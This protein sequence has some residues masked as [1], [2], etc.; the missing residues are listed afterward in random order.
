VEVVRVSYSKR[1][2]VGLCVLVLAAGPLLVACDALLGNLKDGPADAGSP[3]GPKDA[4]TPDGP[5]D[6]GTPDGRKDAR[7]PDATAANLDWTGEDAAIPGFTVDAYSFAGVVGS[8]P[9]YVATTGGTFVGIY[10][11]REAGV[12][13][14]GVPLSNGLA[15]AGSAPSAVT[16]SGTFIIGSPSCASIPL[17]DYVGPWTL[18]KDD[19]FWADG[20]G[21]VFSKSFIADAGVA[22]FAMVEGIGALAFD[23][24]E[25][26]TGL[27]IVTKGVTVLNW[28]S[29]MNLGRTFAI[30]SDVQATATSLAVAGLDGGVTIVVGTSAG[31]YLLVNPQGSYT[32]VTPQGVG[33]VGVV[34]ADPAGGAIYWS[35]PTSQGDAPYDALYVC[36][37]PDCTAQQI[38]RGP[39]TV[40]Q[41]DAFS[42][43]VYWV[44]KEAVF[45]L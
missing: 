13:S 21:N 22:P 14:C 2:R 30:A 19:V 31:L 12:S 35:E 9:V 24:T 16:T 42:G 25:T 43:G 27:W 4:G 15:L 45:G 8:N 1:M 3:D 20:E 36:A 17:T 11:D 39:G 40:V 6:A 7:S 29:A 41:I 18:S 26:G 33:P 44:T 5:K 10:P 37:L 32:L 23:N 38:A 34:A 28:S